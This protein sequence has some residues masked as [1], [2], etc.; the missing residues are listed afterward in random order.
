MDQPMAYKRM[1]TVET[2]KKKP[3]GAA[4]SFTKAE[5][6][7]MTPSKRRIALQSKAHMMDIDEV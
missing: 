4:L 2:R 7:A 3:S 5:I 1:R 6:A